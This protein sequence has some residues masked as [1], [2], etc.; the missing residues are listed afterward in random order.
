ME[1]APRQVPLPVQWGYADDI[2][3]ITDAPAPQKSVNGVRVVQQIQMPVGAFDMIVRDYI[4]RREGFLAKGLVQ[5][6]L[7]DDI[8]DSGF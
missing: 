1:D 7:F 8:S 4:A 6:V 3:E 5:G 2:I